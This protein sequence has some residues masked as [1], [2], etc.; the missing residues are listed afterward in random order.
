MDSRWTII[1][2]CSDDFLR[3]TF[4]VPRWMSPEN[5]VNTDGTD[6]NLSKEIRMKLISFYVIY[7]RD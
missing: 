3:E 7:F 2:N 5:L 4:S 6:P 1:Q